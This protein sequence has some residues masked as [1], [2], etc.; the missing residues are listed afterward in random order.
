M[1]R[2]LH[3]AFVW[4]QHQPYYRLP[5]SETLT[6]PW[7]RLHGLKDYLDMPIRLKDFPQIHQTFNLVPSLLEQLDAYARGEV[8]DPF[9][10]L[11]RLPAK[12]LRDE[13]KLEILKT[14]FSGNIK[15][16]IAPFPRYFALHRRVNSRTFEESLSR[17]QESDY[18]DLQIWFNLAWLD[19][20]FRDVDEIPKTLIE[21]GEGFTE[22]DKVRLLE[23]HDSILK[24][25]IPT[26]RELQEEG[27]IEVSTTPFFHPILPLLCDFR[28]ALESEPHAVLPSCDFRHPEDAST[29]IQM[30][31]EAYRSYF[32]R[33]PRGMW[34]SEGSVSPQAVQLIAD[35]GIQWIATDE[36]ILSLS[37][38]QPLHRNANGLLES[39]EILYQPYVLDDTKGR[40]TCVFRDHRLSDLVGFQFYRMEPAEAA[41]ELVSRLENIYAQG[42]NDENLVSIILDGENCWEFYKNDGH[43]FLTTLYAMLS[44]SKT[45]ECVTIS[46]HLERSPAVKRVPR[47]FSGSW[48]NRNF[49]IWIGHPEDNRAW[50]A[51]NEAR[52][53]L[54]K[55]CRDN[56]ASVKDP[57]K[58]AIVWRHLYAAE[59]S[60]WF[61]WYGDDHSTANDALFDSLFREHL[62]AIYVLL[63]LEIPATLYDPI[64]R[65]AA[66][67]REDE[68][69]LRTISPI[70]DGRVSHYSEWL[71]AGCYEPAEEGAAMHRASTLLKQVYFGI[72]LAHLYLRI[73]V[74]GAFL[75]FVAK[76][77]QLTVLQLAPVEGEITLVM[78]DGLPIMLYYQEDLDVPRDSWKCGAVGCIAELTIPWSV[79]RCQPKQECRFR[80][81]VL[82]DGHEVESYPVGRSLTVF[83][84]SEQFDAS[85]WVI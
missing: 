82:K 35:A 18:R 61:W 71:A 43:Q 46:E 58:R 73:D 26:H 49:H 6:Q 11:S 66:V 2:K 41:E 79:L 78:E 29:Q 5:H 15:T 75:D 81:R 32:G 64:S 77:Y 68:S 22:E 60:D 62:M 27:L 52:E 7:V 57:D 31:V 84:P 53:L 54:V 48:I 70:L 24:K 55:A 14:H 69:V 20:I 63:G 3:V 16:M 39:P 17:L 45:I 25:I 74:E 50:E 30:A 12:D 42:L 8:T 65:S 72:D 34:P 85:A 67:P 36:E 23:Y 80:L 76:G 59:G 40:V 9:L 83:R 37:L 4:H 28:S 13:E 33:D 38:Q 47:I 19:P 21:K 51:L 10:E 44:E 56:W 1:S